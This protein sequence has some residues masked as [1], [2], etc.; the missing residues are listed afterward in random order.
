MQHQV[1]VVPM[2]TAIQ[3]SV[4]F[5]VNEVHLN[6]PCAF[7]CET[8]TQTAGDRS[9]TPIKLHQ[10]IVEISGSF[11]NDC[12]CTF[13][14]HCGEQPFEIY[15]LNRKSAHLWHWARFN[16]GPREQCFFVS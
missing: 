3:S 4:D 14:L 15:T 1:C 9:S 7:V 11:L 13:T 16:F 10:N 5:K 12:F 8:L 2:H 6:A